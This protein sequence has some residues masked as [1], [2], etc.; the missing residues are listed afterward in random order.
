M[1]ISTFF[2]KSG[3]CPFIFILL[4]SPQPG[5][6]AWTGIAA[7]VGEG[8]SDWLLNDDIRRA[9]RL[10]YGFR[11]EE[12]SKIGLRVGASA[13]HFD[14]KLKDPD[15]IIQ[16]EKFGGQFLSLYLRWP[17]QL[18]QSLSL[19]TSVD[20]KFNLGSQS[21]TEDEIDWTELTVN[22]GLGIKIGVLSLRPFVS[23]RRINGDIVSDTS[24]RFIKLEDNQRAGLIFDIHVEPT[25][26]VRLLVGDSNHQ[27]MMLSFVREY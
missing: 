2:K 20:Y 15:Y 7:F 11:I 26:Y 19:H 22:L 4:V 17:H 3:Y 16:P 13:G 14:L 21:A 10:F 27:A 25:A 8:E 12:K 23:Y 1:P 18:T 24:A 5:F 9:D 6:S